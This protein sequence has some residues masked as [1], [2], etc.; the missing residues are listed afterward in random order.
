MLEI[1]WTKILAGEAPQGAEPAAS[2][3]GAAPCAGTTGR[4][5]VDCKKSQKAVKTK[6]LFKSGGGLGEAAADVG[7]DDDD[8]D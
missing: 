6:F 3:P 1:N 8:D 4:D 5:L 7:D 2:D